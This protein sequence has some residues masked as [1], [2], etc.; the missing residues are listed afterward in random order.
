MARL[1]A[2][3]DAAGKEY[4]VLL[5]SEI[6]PAKLA[7]FEDVGAWVQVACPRLSI[8]WGRAFEKA[9]LLNPYEAHVALK[10]TEWRSRY[11]MDFYSAGS[12]PWTNYFKEDK[13]D[14]QKKR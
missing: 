8:D 11:P 12:G 7:C 4:F 9:P 1:K 14:D 5:L 3:L 13:E 2:A 6:F 10:K